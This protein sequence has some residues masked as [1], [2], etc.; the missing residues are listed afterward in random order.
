MS[1][2]HR[3]K[4]LLKG[5]FKTKSP[6]IRCIPHVSFGLSRKASSKKNMLVDKSLERHKYVLKRKKVRK[7]VAF[8][9]G[10]E[11]WLKVNRP[12]TNKLVLIRYE[13]ATSV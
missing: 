6:Q 10:G 1:E 11:D 12:E 5:V 2:C 4:S 13:Y 3:T 9:T 7:F 8:L